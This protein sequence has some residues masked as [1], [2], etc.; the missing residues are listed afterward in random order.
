MNNKDQMNEWLEEYRKDDV[1][2]VV[3]S[4][5]QVVSEAKIAGQNFIEGNVLQFTLKNT[6]DKNTEKIWLYGILRGNQI[7]SAGGQSF[8]IS[9]IEEAQLISAK[10]VSFFK[11]LKD[12]GDDVAMML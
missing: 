11:R 5:T 8:P 1:L 9:F 12:A 7:L 2:S 4:E 10:P 3:K 6:R